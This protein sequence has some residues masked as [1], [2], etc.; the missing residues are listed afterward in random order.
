[1]A[2]LECDGPDAGEIKHR[3]EVDR[4]LFVTYLWVYRYADVSGS[5]IPGAIPD[6]LKVCDASRR[7]TGYIPS[8]TRK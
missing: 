7:T 2:S 3:P 4:P 6:N 1:M 8:T 5:V